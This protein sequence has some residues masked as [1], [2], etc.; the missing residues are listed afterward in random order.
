M[1]SEDQKSLDLKVKIS[2]NERWRPNKGFTIGAA[3]VDR[4]TL[5]QND[6]WSNDTWSKRH[7]I[8]RHLIE[9]TVDRNDIWSKQHMI[10]T[11]LDR[12]DIWSKW[13]LIRKNLS[14]CVYAIKQSFCYCKLDL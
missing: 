7:L 4:T 10:K 14:L 1:P 12:N 3:T 13:Q 8:E 2:F 6:T 5:D 9:M 11:T